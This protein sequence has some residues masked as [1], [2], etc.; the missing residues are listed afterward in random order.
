MKLSP[1]FSLWEFTRSQTASRKGIDNTPDQVVISSLRVLCE[2]VLQP[3]ADKFGATMVNSGYRSRALNSAIGGAAKSQHVFGQAADIECKAVDNYELAL[4]IKD[5][6]DFDQLILENYIPGSP[7]SGWVHVS[8][9]SP[10][11]N[12][13]QVLTYTNRKYIQGLIA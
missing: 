1:N 13:K 11:A 8:Y 3:V 4:W 10:T 7:R 2:E 5:N 9:V 12:R 6:L